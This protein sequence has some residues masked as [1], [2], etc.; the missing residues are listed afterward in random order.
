MK[1]TSLLIGFLAITLGALSEPTHQ[2]VITVLPAL[3]QQVNA[4]TE[5]DGIPW[6]Q[7]QEKFD[8]KLRGRLSTEEPL[9]RTTQG[10][11]S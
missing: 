7:E 4:E 3:H 6:V 1:K 2:P 8:V 11:Y 5:T 9:V 10:D